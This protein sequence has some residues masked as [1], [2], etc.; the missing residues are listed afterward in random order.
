MSKFLSTPQHSVSIKHKTALGIG[1]LAIFFSSQGVSMFATPYYQ[2]T[3]GV[4][5]FLLALAIKVPVILAGLFAPLVGYW[6]DNTN[7]YIGRR[8]PFIF[9]FPIMSGILFGV[10][11]MVPPEWT[12]INQ[13]IYF[14]VFTLLFNMVSTCWTVPMNCL[15][16]E[17]STNHHER[18][19][20]MAFVTYFLKF[21]SIIYHWIFPIAQ[22]S[23]FSSVF[24]GIQYVG[25]GVALFVFGVCGTIPAFFV[26]ERS[27]PKE[28]PSFSF[29]SSLRA[30]LKN[31]NLAIILLLI[32]IQMLLGN[33]AASVDYYIIVYHMN[34]GDISL[35]AKW[36]AVMS[37]AYA[38]W[39]IVFVFIIPRVSARIGKVAAMKCIYVLTF[40]AG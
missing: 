5:P 20:I 16:Y 17:A 37:S 27:A 1:F 13:L 26:K 14:A 12:N 29:T 3:L 15:V 28:K 18:T 10:I 32:F 9:I 7:T 33:Y 30:V 23:I 19:Y 36:K 11:W 6:S 34:E 35:G 31:K 38:I 39:G 40:L 24:V 8:R 25:W 4:D 22:L 21:S 2:M